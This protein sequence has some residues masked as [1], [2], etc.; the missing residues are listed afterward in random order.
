MFYGK[1][2]QKY[3]SVGIIGLESMESNASL[4]LP[5]CTCT[6]TL[7]LLQYFKSYYN[8]CSHVG[9][10]LVILENDYLRYCLWDGLPKIDK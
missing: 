9:L 5:A 3:I 2:A 10:G 1:R 4:P 7:L 8:K 6:S